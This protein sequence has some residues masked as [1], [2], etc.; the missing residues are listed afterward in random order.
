MKRIFL[1][2]FFLFMIICHTPLG[3]AISFMYPVGFIKHNNDPYKL[4]VVYQGPNNRIS[5]WIWDP[6][7]ARAYKG[8]PSYM[9]PAAFQMLPSYKGF[10]FIDKGSIKVKMFGKKSVKS[11]FFE[12]PVY[13]FSN[14]EWIDEDTCY[15]SAKNREG[16][17]CIYRLHVATGKVDGAV[18]SSLSDALYPQEQNGCLFFIER[19]P[20]VLRSTKRHAGYRHS[21]C[22]AL[23]KDM[24][25]P[26]SMDEKK[27]IADFGHRPI[28]FLHMISPVAGFVLEHQ[29]SVQEG[30]E[31]IECLYH[32]LYKQGNLWHSKQ[33]FCFNLPVSLLL[34]TQERLY[35]S[36]LP[37]LPHHHDNALYY[38]DLTGPT[39]SNLNIFKYDMLTGIKQQLTYASSPHE[40]YFAPL[41]VDN[42]LFYGSSL[43]AIDEKNDI[44]FDV[45]WEF[46]TLCYL[47]NLPL[48]LT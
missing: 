35:E 1:Y 6:Q 21:V 4:F 32:Y 7:T 30:D 27:V 23:E 34:D 46:P 3:C 5:L 12:E 10:S 20:L 16:R 28:V 47:K 13:G 26:V 37:L 14:L 25:A 41:V 44:E 29:P 36:L 42:T 33:L 31:C 39:F 38:V 2:S 15:V 43:P 18:A 19:S 17:Y 24:H 11:L 48:D 8:L 45:E 22:Q 9:T 40:H